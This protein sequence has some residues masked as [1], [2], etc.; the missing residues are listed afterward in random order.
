M[1]RFA[2]EAVFFGCCLLVGVDGFWSSDSFFVG[3]VTRDVFGERQEATRRVGG[4]DFS[5][6]ILFT[7]LW[8]SAIYLKVLFLNF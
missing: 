1:F 5:F 6:P 7:L 2:Q 3:L 8:Y 4:E